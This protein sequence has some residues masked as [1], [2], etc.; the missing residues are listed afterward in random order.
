MT[1]KCVCVSRQPINR[2]VFSFQG[3]WNSYIIG[4]MQVSCTPIN[5]LTT[6]EM[7]QVVMVTYLYYILKVSDLLDTIFFVMRKKNSHITFLHVY[8][9][10]GMVLA[11]YTCS[12]FVAGNSCNPSHCVLTRNLIKEAT[13]LCWDC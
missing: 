6:P 4:Q 5:Y 9:H 1:I 10:G 2:F 11:S 13:P 7:T 3:S 8:H 12:K